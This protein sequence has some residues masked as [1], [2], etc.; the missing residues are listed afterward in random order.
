[1]AQFNTETEI[2]DL[3]NAHSVHIVRSLADKYGFDPLE[4]MAS[5]SKTAK[6]PT[7]TAVTKAVAAEKKA[8]REAK[9]AAKAEKPKR[10]PTGYLLFCK[11]TRPAVKEELPDLKPQEVIKE[12]ARRWKTVLDEEERADWNSQAKTPSESEESDAELEEND[13]E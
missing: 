6:A 2:A 1:M 7:K 3:L 13:E 4:A 12:L 9:K 8:V 10:P 5:L 11:A